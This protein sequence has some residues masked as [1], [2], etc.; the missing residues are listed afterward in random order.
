[1]KIITISIILALW[2]FSINTVKAQEISVT[3]KIE[4]LEASKEKA[5]NEEKDAL[6]VEVEDIYRRL[7]N[8]E[9]NLVKADKLKNEAAEKHALNIENKIAIIDNKIALLERNNGDVTIIIE[10]EKVDRKSVV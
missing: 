6:K 1:M 2:L 5:I 10:D 8:E 4:S 7:D 9:I 3:I